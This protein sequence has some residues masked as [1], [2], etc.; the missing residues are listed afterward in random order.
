MIYIGI[1]AL[2]KGASFEIQKDKTN[3]SYNSVTFS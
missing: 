3:N 1:I 2:V